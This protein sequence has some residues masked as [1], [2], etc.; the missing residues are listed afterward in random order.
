MP[1][2]YLEQ[3]DWRWI[4]GVAALAVAGLAWLVSW[5]LRRRKP[6]VTDATPIDLLIRHHGKAFP[7]LAI[8]LTGLQQRGKLD[9]LYRHG[10]VRAALTLLERAAESATSRPPRV[11]RDPRQLLLELTAQSGGADRRQAAVA[12]VLRAVYQDDE[13]RSCLDQEAVLQMDRFLDS[14]TA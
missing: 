5:L 2:P 3:L 12:T 14:L 7:G 6:P 1:I 8:V 10:D 13:L 9:G 11:R 4:A